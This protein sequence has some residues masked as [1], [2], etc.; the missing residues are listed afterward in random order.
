MNVRRRISGLV[1]LAFCALASDALADV[2]RAPRNPRFD[3]WVARRRAGE[4]TNGLM[5]S[6]VDRSYL[7]KAYRT[8]AESKSRLR[9][10]KGAEDEL[11][12]RWDSREHG[13]VTSVK[14]QS[15]Y[16]TCWA[17]ATMACLETA[18]LKGTNGTATNDF[19][20]N[21]LAA[22]RVGFAGE[23]DFDIG[24]NEYISLALLTAWR[25][26]LNEAD[27]PYAHP[28]SVVTSPPVCHVQNAV[29]L[30]ARANALDNDVLKRAVRDY[31]AVSVSYYHSGSFRNSST[32]AYYY[33][34]IKDPNH[35][36]TL[37][38][39]D[40][41]YS[42]NNFKTTT[43]P[44]ADGA[45]LIKNSWGASDG[46]N[47]YTWISYY[48]TSFCIEPAAAYPQPEPTNNYGRVYQY[49]PC[50]WVGDISSGGREDWCANVFTADATGVVAAV[51]FYAVAPDVSYTIRIVTDCTDDPSSGQCA[52]EQ[53]GTVA[54]AGYVTVPLADDVPITRIG[55][56]F[57]VALKLSSPYYDAP[58]PVECSYDGYCTATANPGESYLSG[59]GLR[60][61]DL[62]E[63]DTTANFCVKAYTKFGSDGPTREP[64]AVLHVDAASEAAEPDGSVERPF[65]DIHSA[66]A[67]VQAG[68]TVLVAP[69]TYDGCVEAPSVPVFILAEGGPGQTIVDGL[70]VC[71]YDGS[72]CPST[73][74]AGFTLTN[75]LTYGGAFCGSLSNCV[76]R[77]CQ[78]IAGYQSGRYYYYYGGGGAVESMLT[79][80]VISNCIAPIGGGAA[81]SMME[82]CLVVGNRAEAD[83][84]GDGGFGGGAYDCVLVN[85][86]VAGNSAAHYAGGAY[87]ES[88]YPVCNTIVATNVCD[89]GFDN[90]NDIYGMGYYE[91]VCSISDQDAKFVDAANGDWRLSA[92]SPCIDAG[93]NAFVFSVRDLDG[94]NRIVGARVDMGCY[95]YCRTIEGWPT[96]EVP[97]D[98]TPA[99]EAAAVSAA[100]REAGFSDEKAA[101][102]SSSAQYAVLSDWAAAR[103]LAA[104]ALNG[105]GTTFVSAALDAAGLL[106]LASGDLQAAEFAPAPDGDGWNLKLAMEAYDPAKVNPALLM[107]AVGAV[108]SE[109]L[110][111]D[112]SADGLSISVRPAADGIDVNVKPPFGKAAYFMRGTVR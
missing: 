67:V 80:C 89:L 46:T 77:D 75:G 9:L 76:I 47:G 38:G 30:P 54:D 3:E 79:D 68:D 48:D 87:Q 94:T 49:D 23:V 107:V 43:R 40:D 112:Y 56:R 19:S 74:F 51:G 12:T 39:W 24:G 103:G 71:C 99:E 53:T 58:L 6:P 62:N 37:V 35:A 95:E 32:G 63:R 91:T 100:M 7:A 36:V 27:D 15:P 31:G 110:R 5:P 33:N 106:E 81:F 72:R 59:D 105:S 60:W 88:G 109:T 73:L 21:H 85:C 4:R 44:P 92:R 52:L 102:L 90:G 70:E 41:G 101:V 2:R 57:A 108:G 82:N 17:H 42:T 84:Y 10:L 13:W 93:D 83:S 28:T 25:D 104:A 97:V 66:L 96:P 65:P 8:H 18:F 29:M 45:F 11:P 61:L 50:G 22:H 26:P 78:S 98:A 34:R 1:A 69:G 111:G 16:G 64:N 14:D 20:E 55:E 86:T